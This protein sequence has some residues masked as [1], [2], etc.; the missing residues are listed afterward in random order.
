MDYIQPIVKVMQAVTKSP[1]YKFGVELPKSVKH[2]LW[3]DKK[4]GNNLWREAIE[5]ELGQINDYNTFRA[6]AEGEDLMEYQQIPYHIA[7][8]IKFDGCH[9]AHLVAGGH[10][11]APPTEDIYSGV[12]GIIS[13]CLGFMIATMNNLSVCAVDIGNAFHFGKT[14]ERCYVIAG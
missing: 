11:I 5:K 7:F 4:N 13:V 6:P 10:K 12:A 14:R 2:A 9:K 1:Q 3:L 8:D